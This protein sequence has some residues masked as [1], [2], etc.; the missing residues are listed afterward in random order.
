MKLQ[1]FQPG[2]LRDEQDNIIR[3]GSYGKH[4]AFV[5]SN[6]TGILDYIMNN[7]DVLQSQVQGGTLRYEEGKLLFRP[8]GEEVDYEITIKPTT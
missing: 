6:N 3:E 7:L 5:N 8:D 2:E 1:A 4:S